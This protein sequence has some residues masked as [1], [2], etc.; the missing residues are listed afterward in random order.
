MK[1][2][3][4]EVAFTARLNSHF[5]EAGSAFPRETSGRKPRSGRR[6]AGSTD[7]ATKNTSS[8]C[9]HTSA[10]CVK[11]TG[12]DAAT[13]T[14]SPPDTVRAYAL[15]GDKTL[16]VYATNYLSR[17]ALTGGAALTLDVPAPGTAR[18]IE[19][20]TGKTLASAPVAAGTQTLSIPAFT[21]DVAL[22]ISP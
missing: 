13:A 14:A 18:W 2:P 7:N 22:D 20:A 21:A 1:V 16:H 8:I 3:S 6:P 17:D 19:P 4:S 12:S 5:A 15:R 11:Y 10:G 9:G